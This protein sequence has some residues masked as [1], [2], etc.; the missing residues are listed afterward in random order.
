VEEPR[1]ASV[2]NGLTK[3]KKIILGD[4]KVEG[5]PSREVEDGAE[6]VVDDNVSSGSSDLLD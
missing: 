5:I 1:S 6:S 3:P 2:V 4:E